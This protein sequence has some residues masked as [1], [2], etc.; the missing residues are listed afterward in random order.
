MSEERSTTE[1]TGG[2]RP[3]RKR[4]RVAIPESLSR[5]R[6]K[7]GQKAKR[8]PKF[9]FYAL[10]DRIYRQDTLETAWRM[11]RANRGGPGVDGVV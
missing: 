3:G 6:A 7:L 2:G 10:Y 5:L 11:V 9:R 8:E 1:E 4:K